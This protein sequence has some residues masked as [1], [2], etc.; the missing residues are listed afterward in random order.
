MPETRIAR[1]ED[2]R[3]GEPKD[4]KIRYKRR[5]KTRLSDNSVF[6]P[7]IAVA[8]ALAVAA[9]G[10][11]FWALASERAAMRP[12]LPDQAAR[13][14]VSAY[15]LSPDGSGAAYSI[16]IPKTD[17]FPGEIMKVRVSG[18]P[19]EMIG[20]SAV[21]GIRAPGAP[22]GKFASWEYIHKRDESFKLRAPLV[23]GPYELA[24]YSSGSV[25]TEGTAVAKAPFSVSGDSAG[26]YSATLGKKSYSPMEPIVVTVSGVPQEMLDDNALVGVFRDGAAPGKYL[27]CEYVR[28]AYGQVGL[29]APREPG[30]YEL[31]GFSNGQVLTDATTV[32]KTEFTV[33]GNSLGTYSAAP[34]KLSYAPGEEM[35]VN[36]NGVPKYMLD[37]GAVLGICAKG[38][39]QGEFLA[40]KYIAG[41]D[42]AYV[43]NAPAEKGEYEI[44]GYTNK[45]VLGEHTVASVAS[46]NV[47][48]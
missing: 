36:V 24:G 46:F 26:A 45:D 16:H 3:N 5:R 42:G 4:A 19:S 38:A 37:E 28:S 15:A 17:F 30:K 39:R 14:G 12:E 47:G 11:F 44:R 9:A 34:V 40:Y 1:N 20:D 27:S 43:F 35:T 21:V 31:R 2:A 10:W 29:Q 6:L 48:D 18:V 13:P 7:V 8:L 25:F 33:E 23:R 22:H 41:S 32:S